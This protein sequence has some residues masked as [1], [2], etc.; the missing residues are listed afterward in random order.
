MCTRVCWKCKVDKPL[1]DFVKSRGGTRGYGSTCRKCK[2]DIYNEKKHGGNSK[3]CVHCKTVKPFSEFDHC[4]ATL[5]RRGRVCKKCS[6][7]FDARG[8]RICTK[9]L[10]P[11]VHAQYSQ[12]SR[13]G[14]TL[15]R[16][17]KA[18]R[19]AEVVNWN[20]RPE[21]RD[22]IKR[23]R[24]HVRLVQKYGMTVDE[25]ERMIEE[26]NGC[27][28]LCGDPF[29]HDVPSKKARVDHC[30]TTGEVRALLHS[31]CNVLIG[32]AEESERVLEAAIAYLRRYREGGTKGDAGNSKS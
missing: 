6:T 19:T 3:E 28:A 25:Y 4:A 1:E 5:D 30:H 18:C 12:L 14:G 21:N 32:M 2:R 26:Q 9:C 27:C 17:C 29:L 15:D 10:K 31:N 8:I 11:K 13:R 24:R 16:W 7:E 20:N 22:K 23:T